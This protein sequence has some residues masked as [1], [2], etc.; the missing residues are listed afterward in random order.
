[1][2]RVSD[3]LWVGD[4]TTMEYM[5]QGIGLQAV[6]QRDPL[7]AYKRE[8][9]NMFQNLLDNIQ[10]D[11]VRT[12]YRVGLTKQEAPARSPVAAAVAAGRSQ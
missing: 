8:G 10:H 7:V 1:M 6:A 9:H 4:L 5:R 3:N 12:I 11:V 2:L